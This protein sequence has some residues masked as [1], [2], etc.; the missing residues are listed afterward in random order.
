MK[1][2]IKKKG[3]IDLITVLIGMVIFAAVSYFFV[4]TIIGSKSD[5]TGIKGSS[6]TVNN[7]ILKKIP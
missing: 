1:K 6:D 4:T 5:G 7:S 2:L 3:S